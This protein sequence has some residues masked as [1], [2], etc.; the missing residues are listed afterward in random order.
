M[1]L[2]AFTLFTLLTMLL[3]ITA[4]GEKAMPTPTATLDQPSFTATPTPVAAQPEVAALPTERPTWQWP[5]SSPEEQGMNSELL[6][7]MLD[8]IEQAGP[9][10]HNVVIIRNGHIVLDKYYDNEHFARDKSR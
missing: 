8:Y 3:G 7:A 2:K 4:C 6:S 5:T 9:D 10:I 1:K